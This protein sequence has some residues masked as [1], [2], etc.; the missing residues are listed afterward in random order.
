MKWF[1]PLVVWDRRNHDSQTRDRI[2]GIFLR[3]R[4][5]QF[6]PRFGAISLLT[7]TENLEKLEKTTGKNKNPIEK[8]PKLQVLSLVVGTQTPISRIF[9]ANV[10]VIKPKFSYYTLNIW[11]HE[12]C[13][14]N[15]WELMLFSSL[16]IP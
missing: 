5:G 6:S 7:Y 3:P 14:A 11:E 8:T 10:L 12:L 2:L 16:V 9:R 13:I 15:L 1:C 4:I